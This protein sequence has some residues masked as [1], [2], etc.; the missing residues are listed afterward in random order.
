MVK[1]VNPRAIGI[2]VEESVRADNV[3]VAV[4]TMTGSCAVFDAGVTVTVS[5]TD[6]PILFV[7][8]SL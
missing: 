6:T 7:Q 3:E 1:L 8:V 2:A 5:F 4:A